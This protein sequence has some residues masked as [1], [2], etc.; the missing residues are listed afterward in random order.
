ME[1]VF[2]VVLVG[3]IILLFMKMRNRVYASDAAT[4]AEAWRMVLDDPNYNERR[5]LE[6]RKHVAER[7]AR[8][9]AEAARKSSES[10]N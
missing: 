6:E 3:C 9:L 8:T 10:A 2:I 7:E 1:I 4:L 5:P